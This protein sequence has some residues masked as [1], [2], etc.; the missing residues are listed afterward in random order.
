MQVCAYTISHPEKMRLAEG[1]WVKPAVTV[2]NVHQ[3]GLV[4][5]GNGE[6]ISP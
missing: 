2:Q 4:G 5:R 3:G 6:V 1:S